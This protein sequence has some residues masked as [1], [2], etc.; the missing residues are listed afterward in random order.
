MDKEVAKAQMLSEN[1]VELTF[2]QEN[3]TLD[4]EEVKSGWQK[5]N[6]L[7]PTKNSAVLL[8]TGK[9]TLLEKDARD[10]VM[11]EMKAWPA[12]AVQVHNLGQRI[13]GQVVISMIGQ[14]DRIKLFECEEKAKEWL[15]TKTTNN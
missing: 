4:L 10:F 2:L 14:G 3:V 15:Q 9:W 12:V 11:N 7:S 6:Q 1:V 5:A 13:M 8:K